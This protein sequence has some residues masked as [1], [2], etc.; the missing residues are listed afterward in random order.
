[1]EFL[2]LLD[3]LHLKNKNLLGVMEA[4]SHENF[5]QKYLAHPTVPV[6]QFTL[7]SKDPTVSLIGST[8]N[9][10]KHVLKSG[11]PNTPLYLFQPKLRTHNVDLHFKEEYPRYASYFT[12]IGAWVPVDFYQEMCTDLFYF[13][14]KKLGIPQQSLV[15]TACG[16]H[17]HVWGPWKEIGGL[18]VQLF[19][20]PFRFLW[21]FGDSPLGL[22]KG[23]GCYIEVRNTETGERFGDIASI[24]ILQTQDG[25][26]LVAE[27][28]LGFETTIAQVKRMLGFNTSPIWCST[29]ADSLGGLPQTLNNTHLLDCLNT[30]GALLSTGLSLYGKSKGYGYAGTILRRYLKALK[31][32]WVETIA[33]NIHTGRLSTSLISKHFILDNKKLEE[34]SEYL[35]N[36]SKRFEFFTTCVE[37][38]F[39]QGYN[40]TLTI[41]GLKQAVNNRRVF[42]V[43]ESAQQYELVNYTAS[44]AYL[45]LQDQYGALVFQ[46]R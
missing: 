19:E 46:S 12:G 30:V 36:Y 14:T 20:N 25:R 8:T 37:H 41:S 34:L 31:F 44:S 24:E 15:V 10:L 9:V 17:P 22:L 4:L 2:S 43:A 27:F 39:V 33:Q 28:G 42:D 13:I 6:V 35:E 16:L 26:Q 29:L 38:L 11:V 5:T 7:A 32:Y 45:R 21:E 23:E 18:E 3:Y 40:D 1:M